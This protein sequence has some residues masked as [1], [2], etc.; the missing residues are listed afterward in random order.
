MARPALEGSFDNPLEAIQNDSWPL[1]SVPTPT[2]ARRAASFRRSCSL[3][4]S[5]ELIGLAEEEEDD[6]FGEEGR[7]RVAPS[8]GGE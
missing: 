7:V 1:W 4:S 8:C 3:G 6:E 2:M 5:S